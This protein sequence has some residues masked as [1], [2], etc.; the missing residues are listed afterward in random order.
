MEA[1]D[2]QSARP[3]AFRAFGTKMTAAAELIFVAASTSR[4]FFSE[5]KESEVLLNVNS[6]S[7]I[8]SMSYLQTHEVSTEI[9][10]I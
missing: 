8:T 2:M 3:S 7:A 4:W 10:L 5:I 9:N 1:T 6:I